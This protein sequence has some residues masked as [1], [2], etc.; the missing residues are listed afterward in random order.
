MVEVIHFILYLMEKY[1][2]LTALSSSRVVVHQ[3]ASQH[4]CSLFG[5]EEEHLRGGGESEEEASYQE[6]RSV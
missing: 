3:V 1:E 2:G 5:E 4:T 6:R